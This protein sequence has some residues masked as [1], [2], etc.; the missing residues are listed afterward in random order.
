MRGYKNNTNVPR[1]L[2]VPLGTNV[3]LSKPQVPPSSGSQGIG[4]TPQKRQIDS[5]ANLSSSVT[6]VNTM[7]D[8]KKHVWCDA[9][10]CL[11][12]LKFSSN[13]LSFPLKNAFAVLTGLKNIACSAETH[14]ISPEFSTSSC[15][16]PRQACHRARACFGGSIFASNTAQAWHKKRH[17]VQI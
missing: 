8:E 5:V 3:L 16:H 15:H 2:P 4:P 11:I 14:K 9:T 12:S 1:N 17:R 10:S 13:L 7:C 6:F